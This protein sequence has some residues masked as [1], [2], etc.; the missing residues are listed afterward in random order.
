MPSAGERRGRAALSLS[1][2]LFFFSCRQS[3][4][5]AELTFFLS[6]N[7]TKM[8]FQ[9]SSYPVPGWLRLTSAREAD[10]LLGFSVCSWEGGLAEQITKQAPAPTPA[11]AGL[12]PRVVGEALP[13]AGSRWAWSSRRPYVRRTGVPMCPWAKKESREGCGQGAEGFPG[14]KEGFR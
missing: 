9:P 2:S 4:S 5:A 13:A 12:A 10:H 7:S 1:S 6:A 8:C 3:L 11:W 14:C